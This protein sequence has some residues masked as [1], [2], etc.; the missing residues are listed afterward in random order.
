[1][2]CPTLSP[3]HSSCLINDDQSNK[4]IL[5]IATIFKI[6]DT[7]YLNYSI[8]G[9]RTRKKIGKSKKIAEL[10]VKDIE[11]RIAKN[12]AGIIRA[13]R[14]QKVSRPLRQFLLFGL[15]CDEK[16]T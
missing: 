2:K 5:N 16:V 15:F 4:R 11:V 10:A 7:W 6:K 3:L 1:M 12:E 13:K 14:A 9:K 8:D